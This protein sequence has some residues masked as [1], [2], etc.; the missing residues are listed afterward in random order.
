MRKLLIGII[1]AASL[2]AAQAQAVNV[3]CNRMAGS[4]SGMSTAG[5]PGGDSSAVIWVQMNRFGGFG[6]TTFVNL[7]G[8]GNQGVRSTTATVQ[9]LNQHQCSFFVRSGNDTLYAQFVSEDVI[10]FSSYGSPG[11]AVGGTIWRSF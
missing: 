3:N 9:I 2:F 1:A 10:V 6:L 8:V 11:I 5:Y 4:W 7:T